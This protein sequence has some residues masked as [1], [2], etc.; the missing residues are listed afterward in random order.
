[1]VKYLLTIPYGISAV[2]TDKLIE[3]R[4]K[5]H[6]S[7]IRDEITELVNTEVKTVKEEM[8]ALK[9]DQSKINNDLKNKISDLASRTMESANSIAK[10]GLREQHDRESR[11]HNIIVFR[12]PESVSDNRDEVQ[13]HDVSFLNSMAENIQAPINVRKTFRLGKK[14]GH[15]R[16]LKVELE[17]EKEVIN[18]LRA[19]KKLN[20]SSNPTMKNIYIKKDMTPLEREEQ[21]KLVKMRDRLQQ[22]A[23]NKN[24]RATWI[25]RAGKVVNVYR[26]PQELPPS[27]MAE[28]L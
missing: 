6:M 7:S 21:R 24:L 27:T 13:N 4:C 22:E 9:A 23:D 28:N 16:P 10:E 8:C 20:Q 2:K 3:E 25:I 1:M 26:K 17:S 5:V 11:K 19:A 14:E 12:V 18:T 15:D